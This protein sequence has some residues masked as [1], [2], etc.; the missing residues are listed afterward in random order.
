MCSISDREGQPEFNV[1][2]NEEG[3][4]EM[5][6]SKSS[7]SGKICGEVV[8]KTMGDLVGPIACVPKRLK[9]MI[10][11][12]RCLERHSATT[13]TTTSGRWNVE[14]ILH[15]FGWRSLVRFDGI[16]YCKND[17]IGKTAFF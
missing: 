1:S 3:F 4:A 16:V 2:F 12:F 8:E 6:Y 10:S 9:M 5:A 13:G 15:L 7:A 11:H 17:R 14:V